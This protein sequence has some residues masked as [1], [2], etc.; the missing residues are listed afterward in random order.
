MPDTPKD[1]ELQQPVGHYL[2][3]LAAQGKSEGRLVM[4]D[5]AGEPVAALVY[6]RDEVAERLAHLDKFTGSG[7]MPL[8]CN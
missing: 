2:Q 7:P 3:A 6:I 5:E 4:H 8:T 1:T